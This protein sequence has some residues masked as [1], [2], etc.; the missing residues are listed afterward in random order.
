LLERANTQLPPFSYQALL[1]AEAPDLPHTLAFLQAARALS[2]G[3]YQAH[4]PTAD[5]V[6]RYDPVPLRVVRVANMARAQLLVE[7]VSRPALQAYLTAWSVLLPH[8]PTTGR[9]RWHLEVDPLQI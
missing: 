2:D 7:S 3:P 1:T 5:A 6:I 8:V 9:V 4:F